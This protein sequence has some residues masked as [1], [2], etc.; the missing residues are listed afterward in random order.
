MKD[1]GM[2]CLGMALGYLI[3]QAQWD[4]TETSQVYASVYKPMPVA[5][6]VQKTN[7]MTCLSTRPDGR[8]YTVSIPAGVTCLTVLE[9]GK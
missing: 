9:V 1:A 7:A 4:Y 3:S 2:V 5:V 6:E 8:R